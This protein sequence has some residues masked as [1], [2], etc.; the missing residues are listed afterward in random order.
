MRKLHVN[1]IIDE[2]HLFT[3]NTN[4]L[5]NA[6]HFHKLK[7]SKNIFLELPR[8]QKQKQKKKK[9]KERKK[10]KG[11]KEKEDLENS[12]KVNSFRT[13]LCIF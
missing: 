2:K 12:R 4:I 6:Y 8:Q 3:T 10:R 7:N 9:K 1:I 5:N 11:I 13:I